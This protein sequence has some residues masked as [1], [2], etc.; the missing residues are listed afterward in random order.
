MHHQRIR[1]GD[2][3]RGR[4]I[5]DAA[6]QAGAATSVI[7]T[8]GQCLHALRPQVRQEGG[9]LRQQRGIETRLSHHQ[10]PIAGRIVAH[11][12]AQRARNASS[13][14]SAGAPGEVRAASEPS[15][16]RPCPASSAAAAAAL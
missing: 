2:H 6:E 4:E 15:G 16:V 13:R 12:A 11:S 7:E 8:A 14:R 10:H 9:V 1:G 3:L 5:R